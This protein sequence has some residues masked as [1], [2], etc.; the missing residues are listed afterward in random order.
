[1][2][3]TIRDLLWLTLVVAV[4]LAWF[5]AE[6]RRTIEL[7]EAN[8]RR[9]AAIEEWKAGIAAS[10]SR[11]KE[12]AIDPIYNAK[13]YATGNQLSNEDLSYLRTHYELLWQIRN[14]GPDPLNSAPPAPINAAPP[15][16]VSSTAAAP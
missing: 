1:M 7:Q 5:R 13:G 2:K 6:R 11:Y 16:P 14:V 10:L 9:L 4:A 8:A 3:L 15:P 12:A